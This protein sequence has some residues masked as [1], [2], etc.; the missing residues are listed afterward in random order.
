MKI[1]WLSHIIPY[2][3]K[4]G[5]LQRS[6][7][8]LNQISKQH[9]VHLVSLNQKKVLSKPAAINEAV[10]ALKK[11]CKQVDVFPIE[12]DKSKWHWATMTLVSYFTKLPYDV[13][14]LYNN[15]LDLF[16]KNIAK[17]DKYD[18]VH[19]DTI[20]MFQY[21]I[22]FSQMPL[23]L[24]HHNIESNMMLRR[25]EIEKSFFKKIYFKNEIDK[26]RNYERMVCPNSAMNLVVSD[27]DAL[28]LEE[29]VGD[30]SISVIPNGVDLE[31]F[32]VE[33]NNCKDN[34]GLVFAG[35]M[36]Y[37][38]NREAVLFFISE[39]W[40]VLQKDNLIRSVTIIGQNPPKEL[41]DITRHSSISAPGFVDDVRPYI[42]S[43]KIYI[44]PI[45]NGGGTRLKILDALAMGKPLIAT[46]FAVEGLDLK[47][48]EHYIRAE[49]ASEFVAQIKRLE[50]DND[51]C[52][53]LALSGRKFVEN[54]YS[55]EI[56]GA[57]IEEAYRE[58]VKSYRYI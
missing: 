37:Y 3:P 14:W 45:K 36:N 31:Y 43:A 22:S 20:G 25:V 57:K 38:P 4:G 5:L 23:V 15:K 42:A 53:K 44:C 29:I 2:P 10:Y 30:V 19:V 11:I 1:L 51:L 52:Q 28:R 16:V 56:I 48:G 54:R 47:E 26:L 39:I 21:A 34:K 6:Y 50:N 41:I 8:L 24:N 12:S 17:Y 32:K 35:G 9:E 7:N 33:N 13:N 27:L 58:A 18:L 55:W 40:P 46:G 49:N